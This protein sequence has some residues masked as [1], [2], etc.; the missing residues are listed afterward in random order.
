MNKYVKE[1][2]ENSSGLPRTFEEYQRM[3]SV[4]SRRV[5]MAHVQK[6]RDEFDNRK[7]V[8]KEFKPIVF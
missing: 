4:T 3:D 2:M 7:S 6:L 5:P 8:K 1:K